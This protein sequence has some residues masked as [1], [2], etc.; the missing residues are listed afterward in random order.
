[1]NEEALT[2]WGLSRHKQANKQIA[3]VVSVPSLDA[4]F[5]KVKLGSTFEQ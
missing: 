2:H 5:D 4:V 3:A 1:V